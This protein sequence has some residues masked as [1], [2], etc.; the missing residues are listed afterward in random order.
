MGSYLDGDTGVEEGSLERLD[1]TIHDLVGFKGRTIEGF[2]QS[3]RKDHRNCSNRQ[4]TVPAMAVELTCVSLALGYLDSRVEVF[5][6][7]SKVETN[8][9]SYSMVV[10]CIPTSLPLVL[11]S[12]KESPE[13]F[14]QEPSSDK[15]LGVI[16]EVTNCDSLLLE[17][18]L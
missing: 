16:H 3:S 9:L 14:V 17:A 4:R 8:R 1:V 11:G 2:F 18:S 6:I 12:T 10:T 7:C 5:A 15:G 13:I